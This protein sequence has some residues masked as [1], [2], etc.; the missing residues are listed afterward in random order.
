M[1]WDADNQ[2]WHDKLAD[3]VVVF[4]DGRTELEHR[5]RSY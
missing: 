5:R 3:D 4:S 2:C 1:L